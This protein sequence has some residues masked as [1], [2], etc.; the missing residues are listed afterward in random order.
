MSKEELSINNG[1]HLYYKNIASKVLRQIKIEE[2]RK[3]EED[4]FTM[5]FNFQPHFLKTETS[6][7]LNVKS[8]FY[9][10]SIPITKYIDENT[11][12]QPNKNTKI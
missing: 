5:E 3:N 4:S 8:R 1:D 2:T 10:E 11:T 6:D 12:F 9:R 7:Y